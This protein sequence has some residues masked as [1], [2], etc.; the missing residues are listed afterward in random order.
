MSA[1]TPAIELRGLR[2]RYG[3]RVVVHNI[4]LTVERGEFVTI[5]GRSGCGKSTLLNAL[6][7]FIDKEGYAAILGTFGVI[8]Q[9]YAVFPWLTVRG[10]ILFGFPEKEPAEQRAARL[11]SLLDMT[12]LAAEADKYPAELSGGQVQ[13]VACARALA[14]EPDVLLMDEPFGALDTYTRNKMQTWLLDVWERH[15]QSIIFVTHSIEEAIF[16]SDRIVVLANGNVVGTF[17]V[18][19]GRPRNKSLQYEPD[20]VALEKQ[21]ASILEKD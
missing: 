12:G 14:R 19:F 15:R 2:V 16:L 11:K 6:G 4:D 10:N 17:Q 13:R 7:G 9:S 3:D 5:V 1:S 20:F 8:F 18:P 21:I